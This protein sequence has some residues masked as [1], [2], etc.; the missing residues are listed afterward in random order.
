[1][2]EVVEAA[3]ARAEQV[4]PRARRRSP[5]RAFDRA[6]RRGAATRGRLL[7]RRPDLGQGQL[8]RRRDAD[9]ARHRRLGARAASR[10][11]GDFARMF[12]ATG[13]IPLGKSQ[14]SEYGFLPVGRAPAAR[15]G[16]LP[17]G[18]RPHGGR[19]VGG[20]RR[21]WSR[22]APYRSRTPTTAA[23]RSG[24]PP[25]VN[26]LVGLKPTRDRLAQDALLRELPVRIV[27]DGVLTRTRPRHGGVLPGGREGLPR[28]CTCRRSATSPGPAGSGCGSRSTPTALGR[29]AS[30]GGHRADPED[31]GPARGAR[32]PRRGGRRCRSPRPSATTSS[33]TGRTLALLPDPH[34]PPDPRPDRGT[35]PASTTSRHGLAR[36]AAPHLHKL[37]LA[38]RRLRRSRRSAEQFFTT[39]DVAPDADA[40]HRDPADRAPRPDAGLRRRSWTGCSTGWSFTPWQNATG[41]PAISLPLATTASRAAAGDDVRRRGGPRG[42]C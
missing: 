28:R 2:P 23:A 31:R 42:A 24:S 10:S 35:A 21:R 9:H 19:L 14:L 13:L 6:R 29:P 36:H 15:P 34:R 40:G 38:I 1:M 32:P 30:P 3:I 22:P 25:S 11:D 37:P 4:D 5:T 26:G 27:S 39:Y 18:P 16:A 41:E 33:S 7:R 8:R 20:L 17:V 12:L